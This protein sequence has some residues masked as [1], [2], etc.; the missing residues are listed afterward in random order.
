MAGRHAALAICALIGGLGGGVAVDRLLI[1]PQGA[2]ETSGRK[3]LYWVAPM[4][5]SFRRDAPGKSPMGKDLV[6]VYEGAEPTGGISEVALSPQEINAIGV[7]TAVAKREALKSRID[8]VGFVGYDEHRTTHIHTRA[9][10]WIENLHVRAVG[11]EV[12]KG[13]LLF[14][15]YAPKITI[16]MRE[17]GR[18]VSHGR[19]NDITEA[20]QKLHNFG[21]SGRQIAELRKRSTTQRLMVYA[22]HDGVVV[23]LTAAQGMYLA[24]ETNAMT[25]TDL[26]RIWIM[27]DVF[28]RDIGRMVPNMRAQARLEHLPGRVFEGV[29]DY[30][31]PE[32]D[33]KTRTLP[34][35]L[36]FKNPLRLLKPNMF[37]KV[38]LFS[39]QGRE[40][41]TV[42][43]E[44]VIRTGR[45][46]RVIMA[47]AGGRFRP[48]LITT[49]LYE[50]GRVEIVQGLQPGERVVAS[51][52]FLID[53]ESNLAAGFLR[54]APTDGAPAAGMGR[55]VSLDAAK[56]QAVVRHEPIKALDWPAM[57]TAF[58]VVRDVKLNELH[59]GDAVA[60]E[61]VRGAD[62]QLALTALGPPAPVG[63]QGVGVVL[64]VKPETKLVTISHKPIPALGWPATTMDFA[65]GPGLDAA[66]FPVASTIEFDL[67]KGEGA[68]YF[69]SAVKPQ[70]KDRR[71]GVPVLGDLIAVGGVINSVDA[72]A[73]T[74][75][76]THDAIAELGMRGLTMNFPLVR[77]LDLASLAIHKRVIIAFRRVGKKRLEVVA[78]I[79][80]PGREKP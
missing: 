23:A 68:T 10:G 77:E 16:A 79:A 28:E 69:I 62:G 48:R 46:E 24:P 41:V 80:V 71:N 72:A 67:A 49:G 43:A 39:P 60:F 1:A 6:P 25:L 53:S 51:A 63:A 47:L 13:E 42:P 57:T 54:M 21:V 75:N 36:S 3:V 27:A 20:E 52:Q 12:H 37:A 2:K 58:T 55:L 35:R 9:E 4:D 31:Y 33:T 44:A 22:P 15:F 61:A 56:R 66:A 30:V 50:N 14:E 76:I 7:R 34:V 8:T 78:A 73:R 17:L 64:A 18:A 26:S 11:D 38:T 40:A 19:R 29:V 59:P 65:M 45:A 74:A 32:V 70:A 5:P